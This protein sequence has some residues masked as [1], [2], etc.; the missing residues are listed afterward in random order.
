MFNKTLALLAL[1]L[2]A[3]GVGAA[4]NDGILARVDAW[5]LPAESLEFTRHG[6]VEKARQYRIW[7]AP[8][9]RTLALFQ[10]PSERGQKVLMLD[11]AF[12]LFIP[13]AARPVRI[14]PLQK[15]IG[16]AA[17]GDIASLSLADDYT[18]ESSA[19][20]AG[21][22]RLELAARRSGVTYARVVMYV[23]PRTFAPRRAKFHA[24]SG[25]LL[26]EAVF[27]IDDKLVRSMRISDAVEP[28]RV[29]RV[30]YL[31]R[32]A[33]KFADEIFNPAYLARNPEL[34]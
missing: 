32:H 14:T 23:D 3:T 27:E 24:S 28:D 21:D 7:V 20:E 6:K 16:D 33:R 19:G 5:R 13:N 26:K 22:L 4:G 1:L 10:H 15:L 9:R 25:K 18:V 12:W 29:T 8:G 2:A 31:A 17:V 11:D 34:K 30:R